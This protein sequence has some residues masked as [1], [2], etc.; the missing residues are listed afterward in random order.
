MPM[1]KFNVI[2]LIS[3][4]YSLQ[5]IPADSQIYKMYEIDLRSFGSTKYDF[6]I[7][8][9]VSS[10]GNNKF[11]TEVQS[12]RSNITGFVCI[13]ASSTTTDYIK[14][15]YC[16]YGN[17]T[18]T[19]QIFYQFYFNT[20]LGQNNI[21]NI[22]I[23]TILLNNALESQY[24]IIVK[25]ISDNRSDINSNIKSIFVEFVV[26]NKAK[27]ISLSIQLLNDLINNPVSKIIHSLENKDYILAFFERD[28]NKI[29][30]FLEEFISL[31]QEDNSFIRYDLLL[32]L[33]NFTKNNLS[34]FWKNELRLS[35]MNFDS[36]KDI[37]LLNCLYSDISN[38]FCLIE[39]PN[40]KFELFDYDQNCGLIFGHLY[41]TVA[42]YFQEDIEEK[43]LECFA[44]DMNKNE[45]NFKHVIDINKRFIF[46]MFEPL[47]L[48]ESNI[49]QI[50]CIV[51]TPKK[52]YESLNI[53]LINYL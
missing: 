2:N 35:G 36:F 24:D 16:F 27:I 38:L 14:N 32:F 41:I 53:N 22:Q 13:H 3:L 49:T 42:I 23:P 21:L 30:N 45:L 6:F 8:N 29:I 12:P 11:I 17:F 7:K 10:D 26:S 51:Q 1:N 34:N 19:D 46:F 39:D 20:I 5:I 25:K 4:I 28:Y 18:N 31:L 50:D 52:H 33:I 47:Y 44:Y 43:N 9:F 37:H 40:C 15:L 48:K